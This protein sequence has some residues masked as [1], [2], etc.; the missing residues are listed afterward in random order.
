MAAETNDA[1]FNDATTALSALTQAKTALNQVGAAVANA[2]SAVKRIRDRNEATAPPPVEENEPIP[3]P[4]NAEFAGTKASQFPERI[5]GHTGAIS[6]GTIGGRQA[7]I[8]SVRNSDVFPN[9][10]EP[11]NNPRAQLG[12]P[13]LLKAGWE[14][15]VRT[16]FYI[17]SGTNWSGWM[18]FGPAIYGPPYGGSGP[19]HIESYGKTL[20]WGRSRTYGEDVPWEVPLVR[21]QWIEVMWH[22]RMGNATTGFAELY[23]N[24]AIQTLHP[25]NGAATTHLTMATYDTNVNGGDANNARISQY[26]QAGIIPGEFKVGFTGLWIGPTRA[27]V[28]G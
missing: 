14:G 27:S 25:R 16:A 4:A 15:W 19:L 28:G 12:S 5:S 8:F 23:Y 9:G 3:P 17:P 22:V 6:E 21:D 18:N 7:I 26:R 11:T 20:S 13:D 2:E 24:G 1:D 10:N